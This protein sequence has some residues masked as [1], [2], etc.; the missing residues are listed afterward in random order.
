MADPNYYRFDPVWRGIAQTRYCF[1]HQK[2][3]QIEPRLSLLRLIP[4]FGNH[5]SLILLSFW[6]VQ[7]WSS[8]TSNSNRKVHRLTD[9]QFWVNW[10]KSRNFAW[11]NIS[12]LPL[13]WTLLLP[14]EQGNLLGLA[15][16]ISLGQYVLVAGDTS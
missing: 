14:L 8:H 4:H 11:A 5:N 7:P 15:N 1:V 2:F 13:Q 9:C 6:V 16:W 10:I 3:L 12:V